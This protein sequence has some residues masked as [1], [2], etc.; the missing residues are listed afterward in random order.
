MALDG[1][2]TE[3]VLFGGEGQSSEAGVLFDTWTWD[4]NVNPAG[5]WTLQAPALSPPGRFRHQMA[6][7]HSTGAL[8]FGGCN[9]LYPF[10]DTWLWSGGNGGNW[11]QLTPGVTPPARMDFAMAG[12]TDATNVLMFGGVQNGD[13][14]LDDTWMWVGSAS[15]DWVKQTPAVSPPAM[16]LSVMCY[17]HS[18]SSYVLFGGAGTEG[19]IG[20]QTWVW[21]G[22][23]GGNWALCQPA[24]T[25][26]ARVGAQM[27]FDGTNVIM[28]GGYGTASNV[29]DETWMWVGG[30]SPATTG[31]WVQL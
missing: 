15:G 18:N 25:P 19:L 12:S 9:V 3:I 16:S 31:N 21:T 14:L 28:F 5:A 11:T 20:P 2:S 24:V 8:M 27:A 7:L 13:S 22:G 4:T 30:G 26:P 1:S 23:N 29:F 17:D 10:E 6:N